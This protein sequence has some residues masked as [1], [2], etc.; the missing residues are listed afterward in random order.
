MI[1][2]S[3]LNHVVGDTAANTDQGKVV[4]LDCFR[5]ATEAA[6]APQAGANVTAG[7]TGMVDTTG[8]YVE[9]G[10]LKAAG[11]CA[12][13]VHW[14]EGAEHLSVGEYDEHG[15]GPGL[16]HTGYHGPGWGRR[17]AGGGQTQGHECHHYAHMT[18]AQKQPVRQC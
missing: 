13:N 10:S 18:E 12:V 7:F 1:K 9:R 17:L 15:S 11:M 4:N 5:D 6:F 2:H 16:G 8:V 3:A 14:H